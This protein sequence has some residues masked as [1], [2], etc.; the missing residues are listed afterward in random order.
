MGCD[1]YE[2]LNLCSEFPLLESDGKMLADFAPAPAH[3]YSV[4][5]SNIRLALPIGH[6]LNI[7]LPLFWK[8]SKK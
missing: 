1:Y 8:L 5:P 7:I 4:S 6:H 2:L 3:I